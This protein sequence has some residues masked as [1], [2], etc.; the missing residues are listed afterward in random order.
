VT[1]AFDASSVLTAVQ[2]YQQTKAADEA[3]LSNGRG[4]MSVRIVI[5]H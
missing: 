2:S 4:H 3:T 1:V 5:P